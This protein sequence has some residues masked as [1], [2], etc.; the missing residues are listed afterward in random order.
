MQLVKCT[1][2]CTPLGS[3]IIVNT[4][5]P[6]L[7][8]LITI[9][10]RRRGRRRPR[11]VLVVAVEQ[12]QELRV[13]LL[14]PL[15]GRLC[16]PHVIEPQL[17]GAVNHLGDDLQV[18]LGIAHHTLG[19]HLIPRRFELRLDEHHQLPPRA[20]RRRHR[21]QHLEHGD[22]RQVQCGDV[23]GLWQRLQVAQ[24]GALHHHHPGVHAHAL[25]H[26]AVPH[27]D[28][29]H[30]R[31][32]VLQHA[33]REPPSGEPRVQRHLAL[34]ADAELLQRLLQLEPPAAHVLGHLGDDL[35]FA[36]GLDPRAGFGHGLAVH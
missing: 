21:R 18:H 32:A 30:A 19:T 33:V 23:H 6:A 4:N 29:V 2:T 8:S 35:Q 34:H 25:R 24:V 11:H 10:S 28:A 20:H 5:K 36:R 26:L 17:A 16:V 15:D 1:V 22:E 7:F 31:R 14:G 3:M 12:R 27:V 9:T 13:A